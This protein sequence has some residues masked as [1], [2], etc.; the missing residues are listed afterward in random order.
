LRQIAKALDK[1]LEVVPARLSAVRADLAKLHHAPIGLALKTLRN[2]KSNVK[3]ALLWLEK[4]VPKHG[5]RAS[6]AIARSPARLPTM[7]RGGGWCERGT[8]MSE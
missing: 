7:R 4:G 5:G 1:P 2:H 8:R 6:R 3:S